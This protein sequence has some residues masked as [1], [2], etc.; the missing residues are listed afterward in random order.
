MKKNQIKVC[1][2]FY[3]KVESGSGLAKPWEPNPDSNQFYSEPEHWCLPNQSI[4]STV[5]AVLCTI[6]GI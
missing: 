6:G 3:V 4:A 2:K 1:F 5:D